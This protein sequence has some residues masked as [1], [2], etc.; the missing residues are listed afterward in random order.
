MQCLQDWAH[1]PYH[2]FLGY[3]DITGDGEREG[4]GGEMELSPLKCKYI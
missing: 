4:G 3:R 1:L 2:S